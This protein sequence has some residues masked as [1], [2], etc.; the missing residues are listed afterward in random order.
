MATQLGAA[1]ADVAALCLCQFWLHPRFPSRLESTKPCAWVGIC[2]S[3]DDDKEKEKRN[4]SVFFDI[5]TH[6]HV[7]ETLPTKATVFVPVVLDVP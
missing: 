1:V 7:S 5:F 2:V 6:P 3:N 4:M